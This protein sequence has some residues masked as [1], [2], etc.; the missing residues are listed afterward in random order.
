MCW[1]VAD[2]PKWL[3]RLQCGEQDKPLGSIRRVQREALRTV[4][5]IEWTCSVFQR[6]NS[7][8]S[9]AAHAQAKRINTMLRQKQHEISTPRPLLLSAGPS[10]PP[11][12]RPVLQQAWQYTGTGYRGTPHQSIPQLQHGGASNAN[13]FKTERYV[14][15]D[16]KHPVPVVRYSLV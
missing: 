3:T 5:T 11:Q 4:C 6:P 14:V 1:C 15:V 12:A 10:H 9:A 13:R 2:L 16:L 8:R 7:A